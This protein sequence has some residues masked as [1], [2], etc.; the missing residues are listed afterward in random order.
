MNLSVHEL[1]MTKNA[2]H[3]VP[4][5][6]LI[7]CK[8]ALEK[9]FEQ[10]Q[11]REHLDSTSSQPPPSNPPSV[12]PAPPATSSAANHTLVDPSTKPLPEP[13]S[14]SLLEFKMI[15]S[16]TPTL[17]NLIETCTVRSHPFPADRLPPSKRMCNRVEPAI[18]LCLR[19]EI[20]HL[21]GFKVHPLPQ[22]EQT[23][24]T[25]LECSIVFFVGL[26]F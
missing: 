9:M 8:T 16:P 10:Q 19:R 4:L 25:M 14:Q 22:E 26:A 1:T 24:G 5:P 21:V 23:R 13:K 15:P 6:T 18:S 11:L 17:G 12:A 2:T 20:A 7:K 3:R